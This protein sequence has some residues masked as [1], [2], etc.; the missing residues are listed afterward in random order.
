MEQPT[1]P[2][3]INRYLALNG[4]ATRRGADELI[5]K[6][7]VFINGRPAVLGDKVQATDKVEVK[8]RGKPTPMVYLAY[9]KP[10]GIAIQEVDGKQSR[11][12]TALQDVFPIGGLEKESRGLVI[13]TND[14]R[15]T[16][17]LLSSSYRHERE[18]VVVTKNK[19]RS[20]FKAKMEA[21]V[22]IDDQ[23]TKKCKVKI[24]DENKFRVIVTEEIRNQIRR[25]C[26][27]LFQEVE[28]VQR[29]RIMNISLGNM[30]E[31]T[32]RKIDGE[33]LQTFLA[34]LK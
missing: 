16:Q 23:Q 28:D 31:G 33:E 24:V 6:K 7:L 3:R 15:I 4:R 25:M 20:S 19:L 29:V 32:Q 13:L 18:Y 5:Q 21:G 1:F 26:V 22:K 11:Q 10:K 27:A 9:N 8:F 12:N 2:M 14:G 17:K 34:N 30:K